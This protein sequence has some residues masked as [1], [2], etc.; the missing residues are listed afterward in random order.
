MKEITEHV[1]EYLR[2][3]G[4][5]DDRLLG[6]LISSARKYLANAGVEESESDND[7]YKLAVT[8]LVTQWYE[9]RE[10]SVEGRTSRVLEMGLQTIIL[11]LKAGESS[12]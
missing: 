7:L 2:I 9:N 3:T 12:V 4:D 8:M 6:L 1:K 11:Q 5:H 10:Q